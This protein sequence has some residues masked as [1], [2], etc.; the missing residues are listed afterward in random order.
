M[1]CFLGTGYLVTEFVDDPHHSG[2][3]GSL[4]DA[5]GHH[6]YESRW[7]RN[8]QYAKDY[9]K[10]W[11]RQY[12]GSGSR[13]SEWN[14]DAAWATF[15]MNGDKEF[16][17]SQ[18]D[19]FV[20]KYQLWEKTNFETNL[21]L[22]FITPLLDAQEYSA[23]SV[24]TRNK[25][26]GGLGYRPSFNSELYGNAKAIINIAKLA[27]NEKVAQQFNDKARA[28]REA[29]ITFLWDKKR[30]FFYHVQ[31]ENNPNNEL[32]DTMEEV[33]FYPWRF[34]VPDDRFNF[35][36]AWQ[37]AFDAKAFNSNYGPTTCDMRSK[38]YDG[39][40]KHQC[41]WWNG[42]S[43]PY[44][45][46]HTLSSLAT[47]IRHYSHQAPNIKAEHYVSML[48]KYALHMWQNVIH[49]REIGASQMIDKRCKTKGLFIYK[50]NQDYLLISF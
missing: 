28:L 29:I 11:A 22:F 15:L 17:T 3:F 30:N 5:A 12:D 25:F 16:I 46:A 33:G 42:N 4:I 35:S 39:N 40:Q 31:R 8:T 45:T 1:F 23:A 43:W 38:W 47:Q 6:L 34:G 9:I 41:C 19:G 7:L 48:R 26:G 14:T 32:L 27:G 2:K 13:F 50:D 18:L 21:G 49:H 20:K 36:T 37:Q 24:Q 10:F 44:S